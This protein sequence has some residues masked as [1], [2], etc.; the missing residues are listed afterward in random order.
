M[1]AGLKSELSEINYKDSTG[2]KLESMFPN[3]HLFNLKSSYLQSVG[4]GGNR[5]SPTIQRSI[6]W[7]SQTILITAS[8]SCYSLPQVILFVPCCLLVSLYV[9]A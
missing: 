3:E 5:E 8:S 2:R 7:S 4:N 6:T 9:G 1:L